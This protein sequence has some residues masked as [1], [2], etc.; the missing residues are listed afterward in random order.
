MPDASHSE[1]DL[2][3]LRQLDTPTVCNAIEVVLPDRRAFGFT[4]KPLVCARPDLPPIVGYARTVMVRA[5][6]PTRQEPQA[7]LDLRFGYYEYVEQGP[8]PS[9]SVVQDLDD[10]QAGFGAFWGEVNSNI[11]KA[12]GCIGTVTN[13]SVRDL[14]DLADGFQALGGVITP[15]HGHIHIVAYETEVNVAGMVV[16]SGDLIH[17]DQHGAVVIPA[18]AAAEV[19]AAAALIAKREGHVLAAAKTPGATLDDIK[20]AMLA[21]AKIKA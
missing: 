11:H 7:Q 8:R 14:T 6:R 10:G 21:A 19:P 15:S 9:I 1:P 18:E 17:A 4:S 12:L 13:G 16:R 20:A 5:Y 2:D 3:A